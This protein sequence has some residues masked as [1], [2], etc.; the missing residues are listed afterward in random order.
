MQYLLAMSTLENQE[1]MGTKAEEAFLEFIRDAGNKDGISP[2]VANAHFQIGRLALERGAYVEAIEGYRNAISH[3]ISGVQRAE[4]LSEL[5]YS[6]LQL[7]DRAEA[8]RWYHKLIED[9]QAHS[10]LLA[11]AFLALGDLHRAEKAWAQAESFYSSALKHAEA[12]DLDKPVRGEIAFRLGESLYSQSRFFDAL[13]AFENAISL[14]RGSAWFADAIYGLARSQNEMEDFQ[15]ALKSYRRA[16]SV[17]A[18]QVR[19]T[20]DAEKL[21]RS[22]ER[23]AR[24]KFQIADITAKNAS[25]EQN[26]ESL[27]D[28]YREAYQASK[29]VQD[30]T[31]RNALLKDALMG[32]A[33]AASQLGQKET[34]SQTAE[35]LAEVSRGD[36]IGLTQA[37]DLF[38]DMKKYRSASDLYR[39]AMSL[40]NADDKLL[41][42]GW[43]RLGFSHFQLA[44]QD[45]GQ[46]ENL[47]QAVEAYDK[48]I[49][50]LKSVIN[51]QQSLI[52]APENLRQPQSAIETSFK[53][54]TSILNLNNA[55]YHA[56]VAHK[57]LGE[58]EKAVE[59]FEQVI[60]E[61][62]TESLGHKASLC[63]LNYMKSRCD[64]MTLS[65]RMSRRL[66]SLKCQ[67]TLR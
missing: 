60:E 57:L 28:L 24:S 1:S 14:D 11:P 55:R 3:G 46:V 62:K 53:L 26:H 43:M 13:S 12:V 15:A 8:Q 34:V 38:F 4:A 37:A 6:A 47:Q 9:G 16:A 56:A 42:H 50:H 59:R 64:M 41:A 10:G 44:Q 66:W 33:K 48:A 45:T 25:S 23:L 54:Q 17:Y 31:L 32:Q 49:I 39:Q 20:L 27:I 67:V 2:L 21:E 7:G 52:D 22:Q 18:Q 30:E 36:S 51:N 5:G 29:A 35:S 58:D 63:L 40:E 61:D 65:A 19:T